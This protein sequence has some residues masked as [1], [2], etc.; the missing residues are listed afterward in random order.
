MLN[1]LKIILN[2]QRCYIK[3]RI[4]KKNSYLNYFVNANNVFEINNFIYLYV[5]V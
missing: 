3:L 2:V 1:I 5:K 4:I